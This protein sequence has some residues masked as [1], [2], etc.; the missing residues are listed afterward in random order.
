MG[1]VNLDLDGLSINASL[2]QNGWSIQ[3][4]TFNTF[5]VVD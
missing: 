4:V 1:G 5:F 2:L 3:V